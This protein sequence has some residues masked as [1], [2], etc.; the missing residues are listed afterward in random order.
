MVALL[1]HPDQLAELR[2]HPELIAGAV[3]ELL[4]YDP[5]VQWVSRVAGEAIELRGQTL[6]R[7]DIVLASVGAAN[8][9]P[10]VFTDPDRLD[11]RRAEN[12]HLAFGSGIHFCLGA[13][14]ARMEAQVV[15]GRLL[16]RFPNL[17]LARQKLR[18]RSGLTF[19]GLHALQLEW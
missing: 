7:G 15:I 8:R 5:P 1:R 13:S 6:R 2:R 9:D 3:E 4:R 17:R 16:D 18:W 10:A 14:L 19:R 12:K 11:I